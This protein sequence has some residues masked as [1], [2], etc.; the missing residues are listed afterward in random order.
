MMPIVKRLCTSILV[1]V[2][3]IPAISA[4]DDAISIA[5]IRVDDIRTDDTLTAV[6]QVS[7]S[8]DDSLLATLIDRLEVMQVGSICALHVDITSAPFCGFES[9]VSYNRSTT[10]PVGR[11]PPAA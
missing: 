8:D 9:V 4:H 11:A 5:G 6:R 2:L 1:L 3:L 10:A 7:N